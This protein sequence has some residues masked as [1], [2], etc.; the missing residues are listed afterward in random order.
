MQIDNEAAQWV[1]I[2]ISQAGV[3]VLG[4]SLLFSV[5][6]L[7]RGISALSSKI[8]SMETEDTPSRDGM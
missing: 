4:A 8:K 7:A 1:L 5:I 6:F 2:I 3:M